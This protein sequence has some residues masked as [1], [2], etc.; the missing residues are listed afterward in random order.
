MIIV[1]FAIF[2]KIVMLKSWVWFMKPFCYT[3]FYLLSHP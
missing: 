1:L 3:Q 2:A